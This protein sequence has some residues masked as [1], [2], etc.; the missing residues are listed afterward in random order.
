MSD[1]YGLFEPVQRAEG[2]AVV[3]VVAR[4][5]GGDLR[6]VQI[7]TVCQQVLFLRVTKSVPTA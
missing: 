3:V 5:V 4:L 7:V 2:V 1:H 6:A